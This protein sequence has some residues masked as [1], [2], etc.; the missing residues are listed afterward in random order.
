MLIYKALVLAG[1]SASSVSN[2]YIMSL[3]YNSSNTSVSQVESSSPGNL[4]SILESAK[5]AAQLEIRVGYFGNCLR[6]RDQSWICSS[7]E[8]SLT[9]GLVHGSDPLDLLRIATRIQDGVLFSGLMYVSL[10]FAPDRTD[11]V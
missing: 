9:Q 3:A 5:A 4:S 6:S 10:Y 2:I 7:Q 11:A 1:S 8:G